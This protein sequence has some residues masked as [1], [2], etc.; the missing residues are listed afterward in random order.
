VYFNS[1]LLKD[2]KILSLQISQL[3]FTCIDQ[4]QRDIEKELEESNKKFIILDLAKVDILDSIAL[5]GL[6]SIM[7][8]ANKKDCKIILTQ[9]NSQIERAIQI[10]NLD[11]I[12]TI[13]KSVE[14]ALSKVS[15]ES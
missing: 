8:T 2:G 12:F 5:S 7:K 6:L 11:N 9:L 14:D 3:D 10:S 4:L 1:K 15:H 13:Y